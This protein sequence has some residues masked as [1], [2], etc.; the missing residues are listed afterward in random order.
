MR[1]DD[2]GLVVRENG[3]TGDSMAETARMRLLEPWTVRLSAMF[4]FVTNDGFKR[5]PRSPWPESDMSNDQLVPWLLTV[6]QAEGFPGRLFIPGTRT[7]MQPATIAIVRRWWRV[8]NWLNIVQGWLLTLPFRWSDDESEGRG[9]RSSRLKVQDYLNMI[10]IWWFLRT[11]GHRATLPRP[12]REC[13][14]AVWRY[15]ARGGDPEPHSKWIRRAY[16]E[17]LKIAYKEERRR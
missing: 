5:H 9:F 11:N 15:Y 8:L 17:T 13:Y 3:D 1:I 7:L 10:V 16:F 2:L 6:W 14:W 12:A 4:H